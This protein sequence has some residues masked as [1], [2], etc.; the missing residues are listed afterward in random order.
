M[1]IKKNGEKTSEK[2]IKRKEKVKCLYKNHFGKDLYNQLNTYER[3]F[4]YVCFVYSKDCF[5]D[6]KHSN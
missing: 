1:F 3:K 6:S 4:K 5:K 2:E